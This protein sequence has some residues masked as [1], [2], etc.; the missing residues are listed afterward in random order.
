VATPVLNTGFGVK[1]H[2]QN[3]ATP[4]AAGLIFV[5]HFLFAGY[6]AP[7]PICS[8]YTTPVFCSDEY[9]RLSGVNLVPPSN[10]S[11]TVDPYDQARKRL[12]SGVVPQD[13]LPS[14]IET[15]F[16]NEKVTDVADRLQ[17]SDVQTF[18]D[19]IDVV[20]HHALPPPENRPIGLLFNL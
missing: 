16:S 12:I 5:R 20:W 19:A 10:P 3:P 17:G 6:Y 14:L 18:I 11:I 4:S 8:I 15:I 13:E 9:L 1:R 7:L 2:G